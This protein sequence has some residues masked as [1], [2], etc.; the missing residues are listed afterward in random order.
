M[1][2]SGDN[3]QFCLSYTERELNVLL[4]V[5]GA[6]AW[7]PEG[8]RFVAVT[9]IFANFSVA[10]GQNAYAQVEATREDVLAAAEGVLDAARRETRT[11]RARKI[12][13]GAKMPPLIEFLRACRAE[14]LHVR[15]HHA[16]D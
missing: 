5:K 11:L 9:G 2:F 16:R 12:G 13:W 7:F 15:H 4:G 3:E 6:R 1:T 8:Q 10:H 14:T